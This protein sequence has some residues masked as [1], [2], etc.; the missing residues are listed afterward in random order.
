[1]TETETNTVAGHYGLKDEEWDV[2]YGKAIG[3]L[4]ASEGETDFVDKLF[5][6]VKIEVKIMIV[7]A[8][9]AKDIM[10]FSEYGKRKIRGEQ[11]DIHM[12]ALPFPLKKLLG[13]HSDEEHDH[14]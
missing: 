4:F 10:T 7:A 5:P 2:Y 6:D 9:K 3:T 8:L 14:D 13:K 11:S 12:T 1:M